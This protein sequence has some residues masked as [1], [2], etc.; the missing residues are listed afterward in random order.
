MVAV[1]CQDEK[2]SRSKSLQ[3]LYLPLQIR[4]TRKVCEMVLG[5]FSLTKFKQCFKQNSDMH[6]AQLSKP[7]ELTLLAFIIPRCSSSKT[8]CSTRVLEFLIWDSPLD[9]S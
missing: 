1:R 9:P 7:V 8:T 4:S 3:A 5:K 6:V 2:F